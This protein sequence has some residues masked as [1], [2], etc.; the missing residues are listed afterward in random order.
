MITC[1]VVNIVVI[2]F[3]RQIFSK[4]KLVLSEKSYNRVPFFSP[5][6]FEISR[7]IEKVIGLIVK[8]IFF[9]SFLSYIIFSKVL[10]KVITLRNI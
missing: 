8:Y 3:E 6:M 9:V 1:V 5:F 7:L 2:F 10:I 4:V